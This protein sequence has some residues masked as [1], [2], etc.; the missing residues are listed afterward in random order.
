MSLRTATIENV[1]PEWDCVIIGAGVA[2]G[3]L[4]N[5]LA[6]HNVKVLLVESKR[7]PR[8][9]V[10]GCCLNQRGQNILHRHE[11]LGRISALSGSTLDRIQLRLS[12]LHYD[13]PM[14]KMLATSRA[15]FDT[16]LAASAISEG[17]EVLQECKAVVLP[18]SEYEDTG[19]R[20]ILLKSEHGSDCTVEA[21]LVVAADG[22]TQSSLAKLDEFQQ[23]VSQGSRI[24]LHCLL[25]P[26]QIDCCPGTLSMAVTATGYVGV[27]P[28][29][30]GLIDVAAAVDPCMIN[31]QIRPEHLIMN[32][33]TECGVKFAP[34]D[35]HDVRVVST[36]LL[37]RTSNIIG[38]ERIL[39][40]GDS[41]G[42]VE[43]FTGEGMSWAMA[44]AEAILPLALEAIDRWSIAAIDQWRRVLHRE[45]FQSQW[46]CKIT[47]QMIRSMM[48]ARFAARLC[49]LAPVIRRRAMH[50]ASGA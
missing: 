22:M 40:V 11:L 47:T 8:H 16:E 6:R 30:N 46:T 39:L 35:W 43:P 18:L 15:A 29:E 12:D 1:A 4:A 5:L 17:A 19:R 42:Y 25:R 26:S 48:M 21:K 13:W 44:S 34:Q 7:F 3:L 32:I 20:R 27:A 50:W 31:R 33:L 9:K 14:P 10:C 23:S 38:S 41:I 28:I 37:T 2:G 49:N 45:V 36:P 24:G